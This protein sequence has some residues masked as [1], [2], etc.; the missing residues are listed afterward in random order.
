MLTSEDSVESETEGLAAG[1]DDY[2][3]KPVEPRRLAARVK[4]LL[5][6][7]RI[8]GRISVHDVPDDRDRRSAMGEMDAILAE[9]LVESR[10][11]LD[12]VERGLVVLESDPTRQRDA[13]EHLSRDPQHQGR[14]GLP[15]PVEAG[16][17][18]AQRREPAQPLARRHDR[19]QS[20]DRQRA[21]GAGRLHPADAGQ[22]DEHRPRATSTAARSSSGSRRLQVGG[23]PRRGAPLDAAP[24]SPTVT[25]AQSEAARATPVGQQHPRQRRAA[26]QADEPGG[27]AGAGA[28]RDQQFSAGPETARRC[29]ARRSGSPP[30]PRSCRKAVM[31]TRMQ[32]ID[33]VWSKFP[34]V[35]RDCGASVRQDRPPRHGG[36]GHRARQDPDRGDPGSADARCCATASITGRKRRSSGCRRASRLKAVSRC[37]PFTRAARSTSRC[38]TM[39]RASTWR[40]SSDKAVEARADHGRSRRDMSEQD[41]MDLIFLPGF[42]TAKEVTSI[43]GRGVGM[44]VVQDEYREDRR[45]GHRHPEQPGAGRR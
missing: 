45:Q 28:Q 34:R 20:G 17:G 39:A 2:I 33:N 12:Q 9:F 5:A 29:S 37:A 23:A 16:R 15:G 1:A 21:P 44:D 7:S 42:S 14:H 27:R 10:E 35:V 11:N 30:S 19:D 36:E 38:P 26:R 31:K 41:A 18:G 22:V 24:P 6:R 40:R 8:Q 25:P 32:P 3:L 43:S 13:R 4:A